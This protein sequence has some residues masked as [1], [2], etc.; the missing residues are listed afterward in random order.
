MRNVSVNSHRE[1]QKTFLCS[2]AIFLNCFYEIIWKNIV[3]L[4]RPQI[5]IWRMRYVR[6]IAK[7][8]DTRSQCV[9][10]VAFPLQQWLYERGSVFR[11]T[12]IA[13]VL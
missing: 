11:Y 6:W 10:F 9:I 12:Y 3:E 2:V 5:K 1:T 7:A 8:T 13:F 4:D